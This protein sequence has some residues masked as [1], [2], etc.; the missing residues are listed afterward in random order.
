MT[1]HAPLHYKPHGTRDTSV[2]FLQGLSQS[3]LP[4]IAAI[5]INFHFESISQ[6]NCIYKQ[7]FILLFVLTNDI[8]KYIPTSHQNKSGSFGYKKWKL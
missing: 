5:P 8:N 3:H 7:K 4:F 6:P 1:V 2:L